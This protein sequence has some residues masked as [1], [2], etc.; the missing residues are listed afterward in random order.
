[1]FLQ[2]K[3]YFYVRNTPNKRDF[4]LHGPDFKPLRRHLS[5]PDL[6]EHFYEAL[7]KNS[8]LISA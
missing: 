5:I 8:I 7:T 2:I 6:K 1:M 4:G 3:G